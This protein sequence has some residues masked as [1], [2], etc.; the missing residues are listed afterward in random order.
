MNFKQWIVLNI[1]LECIW[2]EF[3][4]LK[5]I[6]WN[7]IMRFITK[8]TTSRMFIIYLKNIILVDSLLK[9]II[10]IRL[11]KSLVERLTKLF[12]LKLTKFIPTKTKKKFS[13][14]SSKTKLIWLKDAFLQKVWI[15]FDKPT[16]K[17][18]VWN[19][20]LFPYQR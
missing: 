1:W 10:H 8:R 2:S 16:D 4:W 9:N 18:T 13:G 3:I 19:E 11:T 15:S 7:S 5:S 17:Q 20:N 14:K 12:P 6:Q